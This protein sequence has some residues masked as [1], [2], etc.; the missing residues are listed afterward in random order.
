MKLS[1]IEAALS[2]ELFKI[3]P[4]ITMDDIDRNAELREEFDIDSIDFLN[5]VSALGNRFNLPMP[6]ADYP[7]MVAYN[8]L[9]SYL[10]GK[11]P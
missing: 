9:A 6:E 11:L 10:A 3:A 7:Q 8:D 1:E 4:D 5:L 2:E